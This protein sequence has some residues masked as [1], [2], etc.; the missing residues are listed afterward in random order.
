MVSYGVC[1]VLLKSKGE[2]LR[3]SWADWTNNTQHI[4]LWPSRS[5]PRGPLSH[6]KVDAV[7]AIG[8]SNQQTQQTDLSRDIS[9]DRQI[10]VC[11]ELFQ[12]NME[13]RHDGGSYGIYY[14]FRMDYEGL[15][16]RHV[17]GHS[18]PIGVVGASIHPWRL[19]PSNRQQ[20]RNIF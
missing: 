5:F 4:Y 9:F 16:I 14:S 2:M 20:Q 12:S 3:W 10:C 18:R 11:G 7:I 15:V 19:C 8:N 17:S 6:V 1:V 13:R